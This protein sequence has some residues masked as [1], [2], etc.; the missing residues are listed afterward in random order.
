MQV[1]MSLMCVCVYPCVY[2]SD[3]CVSECAPMCVCLRCECVQLCSGWLLDPEAQT[4]ARG[5]GKGAGPGRR[6]C[7]AV[8]QA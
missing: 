7:V 4:Q 8:T 3:V 6:S 1:G 5:A 2:V